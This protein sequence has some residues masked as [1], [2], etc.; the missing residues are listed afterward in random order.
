MND[1]ITQCSGA[2]PGQCPQC[3]VVFS[4][5][6]QTH[7][8]NRKFLRDK[9]EHGGNLEFDFGHKTLYSGDASSGAYNH[10]SMSR[11]A[12][13]WHSHPAL[14]KNDNMCALGL[15]SP[16]DLQ[17]ITTGALFGT[18]AHLVYAKEGTYMVS[19]APALLNRLRR[20]GQHAV[21]QF[22]R[23]IDTTFNKLHE[24]FLRTPSETYRAYCKRWLRIAR[25][26]GFRIR[27]FKLNTTPKITIGCSCELIHGRRR[28]IPRVVVPPNFEL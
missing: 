28:F 9:K 17:N 2:N 24:Q 21:H 4:V 3:R 14:C 25:S 20:G 16:M 26:K 18:V 10:I 8:R 6:P 27:L 15:P 1:S 5:D 13:D 23:D 11:G 19:L 22:F 12:V 7:T